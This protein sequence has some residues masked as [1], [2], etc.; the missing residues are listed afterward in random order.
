MK[1]QITFVYCLLPAR[2]LRFLLMAGGFAVSCCVSSCH[3]EAPIPAYIHI[4]QCALTTTYSIQGS[5]S[6][7]II[8]AWIDVDGKS[9]GTY[10]MPCTVPVLYSGQH[11]VTVFPGIKENGIT[12]SRVQYQ[13][14]NTYSVTATFTPGSVL[15]IN[16]TTAYAS[17]AIFSFIEDFEGG[18]TGFCDSTGSD[19][20]MQLITTPNLVFEGLKS[21]GVILTGNK[22]QYYGVTCAKYPLPNTPP[23]FLEMNYNCNTE[24]NVGVVAYDASSNYL[25]QTIALTLRP[26][27]GWN[28]V[29][30]NLNDAVISNNAAKYS[31]FFSMLK[32]SDPSYFYLDNVKL[33]AHN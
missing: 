29:Y 32:N 31:I 21:G 6:Q 13:F 23:I 19:T 8:D 28:K 14:Y 15:K 7:K 2:L 16:P 10:E 1:L 30:V 26:T 25:G 3:K 20:S 33:V 27:I 4:D 11:T 5:S 9:V 18:A 17:Y 12:T 24:F 22:T